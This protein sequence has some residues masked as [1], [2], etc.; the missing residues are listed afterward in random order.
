[1]TYNDS[2]TNSRK[3]TSIFDKNL[4]QTKNKSVSFSAFSHL[5]CELIHY[6]QEGIFGIDELENKLA[7]IGYQIGLRQLE[8]IIY[9][10]KPGKRETSHISMLEFI[11]KDIWKHL[12]GKQA[13]GLEQSMNNKNEFFII[14]YKPITNKYVSLSNNM[15]SFNP[16]SFIAGIIHGILD[17][18]GFPCKVIAHET[19]AT[20]KT[21][22]RTI[23]IIRFDP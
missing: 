21:P 7:N 17:N 23:F 5:Y 3:K 13:D 1:M 10:N 9:R 22:L 8:L 12:F 16:A 15:K 6:C 18:S 20:N 19:E 14:D 2:N 11:Q 4:N